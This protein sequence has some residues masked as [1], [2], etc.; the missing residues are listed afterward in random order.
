MPAMDDRKTIGL[1]A[2]A[3]R[4]PIIVARN[5]KAAGYKVICVG[6]GDV[7]DENLKSIVDVFYPVPLARPGVWI[8]KLR[9][10]GVSSTIMVG[11][12]EKK[13]LYTPFRILKYMP[14]WRA[15]RIWLVR[16]KGKD[17]RPDTL[18]N[19]IAD[20]LA[21][22]EIILEDSTMYSEK[23][24]ADDGTM[25]KLSPSNSI[26]ADIQFGWAI[27]KKIGESDIGQAVAVKEK[28]TVA[29]EAIEGTAEMIKRAGGLCGKGW[30]LVKTA[31]PAQDMRFDVPCIGPD[32]VQSVYDNGGKCIVVEAGKTFVVDKQ[33]TIEL[34]DKL[35]IIIVG[36]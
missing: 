13:T 32:T 4:L 2:G 9:R 36:R 28:E 20:E 5:A 6:L 10:H 35:G 1:I 34:A 22:G 7:F 27:A 24:L 19:A 31:K 3:S 14:D 17:W 12:V 25:T 29:V 8:R 30:T 18:L 33:Q 11:K 21:A 15:L 23:D 16:L 26:E